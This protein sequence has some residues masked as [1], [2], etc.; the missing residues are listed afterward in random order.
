M[1]EINGLTNSAKQP[2]TLK[3][4]VVFF[5][6]NNPKD[7]VAAPAIPA[8][9]T[10]SDLTAIFLTDDGGGGYTYYQL[11]DLGRKLGFH[12]DWSVERG[13]FIETDKPYSET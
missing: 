10:A 9:G 8:T 1:A 13:V 5:D 2:A 7:S 4:G 6:S 12:V 3:Y 11:Q